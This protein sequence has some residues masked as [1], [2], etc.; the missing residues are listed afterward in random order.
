MDVLRACDSPPTV[1]KMDIEGGEYEVLPP[2]LAACPELRLLSLEVHLTKRV[3]Q[4]HLAPALT[5]LL[6]LFGFR[7]VD[8]R[9]RG[10]AGTRASRADDHGP[11]ELTLWARD[12]GVPRVAPELLPALL[13]LWRS[14]YAGCTEKLARRAGVSEM[15]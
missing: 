8:G 12:P 11:C 9:Q 5:Q 15:A 3:F 1:V 4:A 2:L 7:R 13:A 10:A 14:T 6:E